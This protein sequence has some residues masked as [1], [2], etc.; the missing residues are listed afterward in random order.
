MFEVG[1]S[2]MAVIAVIAL[3]VLGPERLPKA[4]RMVGTFLRKARRSFESLKL[5]VERELEAD[6]LKKQFAHI[7]EA[8]AALANAL[9]QPF[10]EAKAAL[11]HNVDAVQQALSGGV[12]NLPKSENVG[13]ISDSPSTDSNS[14]STSS[15]STSSLSGATSSVNAGPEVDSVVPPRSQSIDTAAALSDSHLKP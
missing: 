3:I 12:L 5:E 6:E 11:E 4:A 7:A 2:E 14:T 9:Q 13:E 8:P 1:F 10:A 15:D